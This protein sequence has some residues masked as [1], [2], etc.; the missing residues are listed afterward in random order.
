M[1]RTSKQARLICLTLI[2][3]LALPSLQ[4]L[5]CVIPVFR[6]ALE[7]WQADRYEL[8]VFHDRELTEEEKK[9]L[10]GLI[11]GSVER[12]RGVNVQLRFVHL[13]DSDD[14]ELIN[15]WE[16]NAPSKKAEGE[17]F[18]F[19]R[20]PLKTAESQTLWSGTLSQFLSKEQLQS[21]T[22]KELTDRLLTGDSVV[23]L[24]AKS[25]DDATNQ[26][27]KRTLQSQLEELATK[28]E[29]P[30]GIGEPGS[31]L[32]SKIPL[33]VQFTVLEFDPADQN[34]KAFYNQMMKALGKPEYTEEGHEAV[35]VPVFGRGRA[36]EA[37][38][39]S[40]ATERKSSRMSPSSSAELVHAKSKN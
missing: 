1:L 14:R 23:W 40:K 8:L 20:A 13:R 30:G 18:V 15:F 4:S 29:L 16:T 36:L 6:Y 7:R 9:P 25:N 10:Q 33:K 21:P 31:E 37:I 24:L 3:C 17:P 34:E 38:P 5:A 32:Y 2:F 12:A 19:L 28:M 26:E 39:A 35:L 11:D 22:R 27:L